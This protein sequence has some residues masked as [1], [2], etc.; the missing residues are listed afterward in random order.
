MISTDT[1]PRHSEM[2]PGTS[3]ES[4]WSI[5]CGNAFVTPHLQTHNHNKTLMWLIAAIVVCSLALVLSVGYSLLH[6]AQV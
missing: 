1:R 5:L 6:L 4:L 2:H 3:T